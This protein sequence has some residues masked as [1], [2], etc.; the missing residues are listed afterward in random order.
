MLG[1]PSKKRVLEILD[2]GRADDKI[3]RNVDT[4][5]SFM[6]LTNIAAV[7]LE[8]VESIGLAY[9]REF[10]IF[11]IF[12]VI[13][14]G[15]E[16]LSRVWANAARVESKYTTTIGRRL[17]YILS[18]NGLIDLL[19]ILPSVLSL[20]IGD[21]D[22]RWLRVVRL[23]RLLK[24]SNYS[25]ALEDL[26]S[27]IYEERRSFLA[28]LY[29]FTIALFSASAMMYVVENEAQ[30]DVFASIPESMW[31]ALI[32]LT[33]VGYGDV[34]PITPVGKMVGAL[35]ALMGVCTVA[36]LTGII[37]NAFANQINRRKT[38]FEA[39]ITH[40]L[41]DGTIS[42]EEKQKIEKLQKE[43]NLPDAYARAIITSISEKS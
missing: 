32:T 23:L 20:M 17:E 42:E 39:E 30:P 21:I 13:V 4:F 37:A 29:L 34:S 40:A 9:Q 15:I 7:S 16:Y 5:L 26:A 27:A 18:F 22:L 43:Y 33:T 41:L 24:I 8:S 28:S 10:A 2:R 35:T 12:S 6:I 11:E 25:Y 3:S 38:I 19:A 31:W 36:L 14:F 1:L